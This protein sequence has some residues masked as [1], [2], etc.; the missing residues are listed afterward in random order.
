MESSVKISRRRVFQ[1]ALL[2]LVAS[3]LS[4]SLEAATG[5][6]RVSFS[7][8]GFI[9]GVGSGRGVLTFRGHNYPFRV[10][11]LGVGLTAGVSTNHL[12]GRALNLRGPGDIAG[13]YNAIGVGGALAGGAGAVQLQNARG[14]ILQ[15]HGGKVGIE[16]SAAVSGVQI[17]ME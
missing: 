7:K 1:I 4:S 15:L 14:V 16:V 5:S 8:A 12:V 9:V 11:G 6:V 17:T 10:S 3:S 13:S 2:G